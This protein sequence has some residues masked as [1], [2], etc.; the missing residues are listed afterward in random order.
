MIVHCNG[1]LNWSV[2]SLKDTI[3]RHLAN[4]KIQNLSLNRLARERGRSLHRKEGLWKVVGVDDLLW[5]CGL[6]PTV[7]QLRP[8]DAHCQ[9]PISYL[10]KQEFCLNNLFYEIVQHRHLLAH[11][12]TI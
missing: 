2:P 5:R 6:R 4:N 7:V 10:L 3:I 9:I 8:V 11:L 1:M 12:G